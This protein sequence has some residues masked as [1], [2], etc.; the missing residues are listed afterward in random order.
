MASRGLRKRGAMVNEA[1][2]KA[3]GDK[4]SGDGDPH[5]HG[6]VKHGA[7]NQILRVVL[8]ALYFLGSCARFLTS[9]QRSRSA[10]T[11]GSQHTPIA[12]PWVLVVLLRP[13]LVLCFH[14]VDETAFRY[15]YHDDAT[16]VGADQDSCELGQERSRSDQAGQRRPVGDGFPGAAH[17]DSESPGTVLPTQHEAD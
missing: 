12:D 9:S 3:M 11:D 13:G 14:G 7:G 1:S 15:S 17:I 16:V 4:S 2:F 5:A 8:L 6:D 10:F